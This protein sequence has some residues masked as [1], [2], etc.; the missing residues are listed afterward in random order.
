MIIEGIALVLRMEGA[1]PVRSI[2]DRL[3]SLRIC[4]STKEVLGALASND[5]KGVFASYPH[6]TNGN[7]MVRQH[8]YLLDKQGG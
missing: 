8:Y 3:W 4:I 1:L 6:P 5:G 2:Q 7:R